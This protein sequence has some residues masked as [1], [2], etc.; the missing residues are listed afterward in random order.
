MSCDAVAFAATFWLISTSAV[1]PAPNG[2]AA[3]TAPPSVAA[4]PLFA[5]IIR[6]AGLLK[7]QTAT[8]EKAP[9]DASLDH[10][11]VHPERHLPGPAGETERAGER[12]R[13]QDA[14]RGA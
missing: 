5:D 9:L 2:A 12:S 7:S 1:A 8:F 13:P 6:R 3:V 10:P 4:E 14:P 11:E